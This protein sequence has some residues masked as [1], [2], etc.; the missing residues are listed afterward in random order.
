M[1][2]CEIITINALHEKLLSLNLTVTDA[3][4]GITFFSTKLYEQKGKRYIEDMNYIML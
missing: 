1:L 2:A 4:F 3:S